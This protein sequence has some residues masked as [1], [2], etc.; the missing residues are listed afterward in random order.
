A[1]P[2]GECRWEKNVSILTDYK[3]MASNFK[4]LLLAHERKI[5]HGKKARQSSDLR[6]PGSDGGGRIGEGN[7]IPVYSEGRRRFPVS[8]PEKNC[9]G[10]RSSHAGGAPRKA[11][12]SG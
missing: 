2:G 6:D 1:P 8:G 7:R 5:W 4:L 9:P 12:L 11:P 10:I 3:S